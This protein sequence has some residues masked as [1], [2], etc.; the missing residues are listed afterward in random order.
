MK[1]IVGDPRFKDFQN[2]GT[3]KFADIYLGLHKRWQNE[4]AT[5]YMAVIEHWGKVAA[6]EVSDRTLLDGVCTL[7][8]ADGETWYSPSGI[9]TMIIMNMLRSAEG[10]FQDFLTE[11]APDSNFTSGQFL[12]G[13]RSIPMEAQEDVSNIAA[14]IKADGPLT[15]LVLTTPVQRLLARLQDTEGAELVTVAIEKHLDRYGHQINTLDFAEPTLAEDPLLLMLNLKALVQD[16]NHD[17]ASTQMAL[18][19]K[20]QQALIEVREAF[21]EADWKEFSEFMW[22]MTRIYPHR[23][24]ALFYLGAGWPLLRSLALE[25]GQRLVSAGT[26]EGSDDVFFLTKSQL[27]DAIGARET[28]EA[29]P[30]LRSSVREQRELQAAR[31]RLI[32]P[33]AVPPEEVQGAGWGKVAND[34]NSN[35]LNG[36]ACSPGQI[37]ARASLLLSTA[38]F[39]NM[40]PGTIL[41]CPMTTPAWTQLFSQ[42]RGLVTDIGGILT[43]GSIVAREYGIPAVLG[44]G[45]ATERIRHGQMISVD[46]NSGVFTLLDD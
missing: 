19:R 42:A 43:H 31:M 17:P 4:T 34:A 38:D 18:A 16:T 37:T 2:H 33:D 30:A 39:S 15:D 22:I 3:D 7:A 5:A 40:V 28:G 26:L 23:D 11:A 20:R 29:T 21:S 8:R 6:K 36:N 25:L 32:P 41:V 1:A 10:V 27:E 14:F 35:E 46:G 12:S 24:D 9:G 45:I 13:L 44:L